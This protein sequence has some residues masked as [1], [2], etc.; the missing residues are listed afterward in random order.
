VCSA[1][2]HDEVPKTFTLVLVLGESFLVRVHLSDGGQHLRSR[3]LTVTADPSG[4]VNNALTVSGSIQ[5]TPVPEP[6]SLALLVAGLMTLSLIGF[7]GPRRRLRGARSAWYALGRG[8]ARKL[9]CGGCSLQGRA[10]EGPV[11]PG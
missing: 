3:F 5:I 8:A 6:S 9:W 1:L 7:A 4:G 11:Q 2:R 10:M